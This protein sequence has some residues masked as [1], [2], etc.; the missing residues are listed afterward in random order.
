[1]TSGRHT[2]L[3][4]G[5]GSGI[6]LSLAKA[7]HSAGNTVIVA[8]RR[9][10]VLDA[11]ASA[12]P[13]I[14]VIKLD[15]ADAGSIAVGAAAL[16]R[17]HPALDTVIH[18]AGIMRQEI[19]IN[20][21]TADAEAMIATNLLGPI[22]LTAAL[23][24]QLL[25][26]HDATIVTVSSG[27]GFVPMALVPTYCA[28][29]AAIHSW[30]QSLRHQLRETGVKVVEIIPPYVQTE[31]LSERQAVDPRAMPLD[32]FIGE[33]MALLANGSDEVVVKR[34]EALRFAAEAGAYAAAYSAV[35]AMEH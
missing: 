16:Q 27:L 4:T 24:P 30:T 10:A 8:S 28:T 13:G 3:I 25:Q 5:G 26:R 29:K 15:V 22:R 32:E 2:I 1:M 9:Q 31:L 18:N 17:D 7:L 11:V 20:G 6:G 12:Y 21:D 23:M 19:L 34:G 35:N 33:V 14:S